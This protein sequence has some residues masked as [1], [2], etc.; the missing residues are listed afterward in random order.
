VAARPCRRHAKAAGKT[1]RPATAGS[2]QRV[3]QDQRSRGE[4]RV[5]QAFTWKQATAGKKD[6]DG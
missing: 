4:R 2:K 1:Q 6:G 3:A 5:Q